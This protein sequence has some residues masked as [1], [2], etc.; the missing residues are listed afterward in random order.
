MA[1]AGS[2]SAI[3]G[4]LKDGHAGNRKYALWSLSLAIDESNQ[5]TLLEEEAVDPIVAALSSS[6]ANTRR[7]A[8]AAIKQLALNNAVRSLPVTSRGTAP[9]RQ[10]AAGCQMC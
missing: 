6:E 2:M 4:L 7:Q 1:N 8:A 5:K 10:I 9:R 3:I